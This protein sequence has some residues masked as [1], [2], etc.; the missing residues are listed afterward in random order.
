[1]FLIIDGSTA[2][3]DPD[4]TRWFIREVRRYKDTDVDESW[5]L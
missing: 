5:L 1:M 2:G 4:K 3:K